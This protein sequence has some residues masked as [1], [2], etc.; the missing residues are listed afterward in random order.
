MMTT[1]RARKS[2]ACCVL[3]GCSWLVM[4]DPGR[5]IAKDLAAAWR[6]DGAEGVYALTAAHR[7]AFPGVA[8]KI[9]DNLHG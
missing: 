9:W 2:S 1:L 3:C 7:D 5:R 4:S 6:L 8:E